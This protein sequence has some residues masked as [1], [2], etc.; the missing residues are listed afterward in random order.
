LTLSGRARGEV[1]T[2]Y[3]AGRASLCQAD[4]GN[5]SGPADHGLAGVGPEDEG[6]AAGVVPP[7]QLPGL[8]EVGVAPEQ[9]RLEPRPPAQRHGLVQVLVGAFVAGA[10]A[11]AVHQVQRLLGV[12]Q[13]HQQ[14]V[15]APLPVVADVHPLL[16]LAEG[17]RDRAVGVDHRPLPEEGRPLP[18]PD[19]QAHVVDRLHQRQHLR[20]V[21]EPAAEVAGGRGVGDALCPQRVEVGLVVAQQFQV[22]DARAAGQ[23]VVGQVQ[24]V[25]ALVVGQVP[26]EQPDA[27]VDGLRQPDAT[28]QQVDGADPAAADDAR[29]AGHLVADV[30]GREHRARLVLPAPHAQ[31]LLNSRL[32]SGELA[33]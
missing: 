15:V 32:A 28:R 6:D 17:G 9:H 4:S 33:V 10:V 26:L 3:F 31:P 19:L 14:R 12:G 25:V 22:L 8:H 2:R 27:L 1:F 23:H 21:P 16:A 7:V 20:L 24:H 13:R 18:L 5:A 30:A 29:A 11:R